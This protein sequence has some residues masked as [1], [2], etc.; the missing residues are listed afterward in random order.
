MLAGLE[1]D[2]QAWRLMSDRQ[3]ELFSELSQGEEDEG[4]RVIRELKGKCFPKPLQR[5]A[6]QGHS[7][8]LD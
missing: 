7:T 1:G 3:K 8:S 5:G 2:V 4:H 6:E